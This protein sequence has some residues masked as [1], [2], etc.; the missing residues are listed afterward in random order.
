V[1]VLPLYSTIGIIGGGQLGRMLALAA[2]PLGFKVK[3]FEPNS[4][5]PAGLITP[6]HQS[7]G[8]DD[9]KAL[10]DF[11]KS[12]D[13]VTFE[14]ENIPIEAARTIAKN[15]TLFPNPKSLELTQDR[16]VE[17]NFIQ[18]LGLVVA[19]YMGVDNIA[20]LEDAVNT[21]GPSGI[22]KTRALGYDGKGQALINGYED[23]RNAWDEIGKKPAIFEGLVNFDFET[24]IILARGQD[25]EIVCFPNSQNIH[26]G[27]I[28]R[29]SIVPAPLNEKQIEE[30]KEIGAI[31]ADGLNYV[32]VLAVELFVTK[33]GM[34]VNEIAPRVHNSGHWTIEGCKTSQFEAHIRAICG[35][36]LGDMTLNAQNI[37]MENLIGDE[38]LSAQTQIGDTDTFVHIYGKEK[39]KSGRKMG[40]ITRLR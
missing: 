29:K 13:V 33:T 1:K 30:A 12:C 4:P 37:E 11:A 5:C 31:I 40:H 21:I 28:L 20:D 36:P 9:E 39:V 10:R 2:F 14:F 26:S 22:I 8:Y 15:T 35:L 7:S 19:P 18:S 3:I 23:A 27:G 24:S 32:G 34:V 25:G 38:I 17:K 16:L 6:F